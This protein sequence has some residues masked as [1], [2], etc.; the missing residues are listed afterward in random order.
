[1]PEDGHLGSFP[2]ICHCPFLCS[3]SPSLTYKVESALRTQIEHAPQQEPQIFKLA[4]LESSEAHLYPSFTNR[5]RE[6]SPGKP[7]SSELLLSGILS[8]PW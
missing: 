1:M 8:C 6:L 7:G 4:S 2:A 5:Y 3:V